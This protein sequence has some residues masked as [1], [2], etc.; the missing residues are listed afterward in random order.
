M[1]YVVTNMRSKYASVRVFVEINAYSLRYFGK[2]RSFISIIIHAY[3]KILR[4]VVCVQTNR[5]RRIQGRLALKFTKDMPSEFEVPSSSSR[6]LGNPQRCD[7]QENFYLA[8][9]LCRTNG[10][11]PAGVIPNGYDAGTLYS[12]KSNEQSLP[13]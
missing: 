6:C 3:H 9:L 11:M 1:S 5:W 8:P 4:N 12:I 13:F 10:W 2:N 7:F